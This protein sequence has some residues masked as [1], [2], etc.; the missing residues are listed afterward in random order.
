MGVALLEGEAIG[1]EVLADSAYGSGA[2]R[3]ALKTA[4]HHLAVKPLPSQPAVAGGL[5][6]DDFIVDHGA[7]TV[8]CPAGHRAYLSGRGTARFAPHCATCPLRAR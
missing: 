2:V 7:R 6:G 5:R 1:L 8:T 4:G 3:S